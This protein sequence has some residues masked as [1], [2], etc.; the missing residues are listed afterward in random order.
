[1]SEESHKDTERLDHGV[2]TSNG[3]LA[4][5]GADAVGT[6]PSLLSP[7]EFRSVL[8]QIDTLGLTWSADIPPLIKPKDGNKRA[9]L[10]SEEYR[11]I[12]R[13][14]PAFPRE[15]GLVM[16]YVLTG[17]EMAAAISGDDKPGFESKAAAVR[18]LLITS[19]YKGEFFFKYA[20]KV[21]YLVDV[22]WEIVIKAFE[23]NVLE[24]PRIPY[25]LLSLVFRQPTYPSLPVSS[26]AASR[27][28][29]TVAV[30]EHLIDML[31]ETL[32]EVKNRLRAAQKI[33]TSLSDEE[34]K[35]K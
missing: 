16:F 10:L 21:P 9:V 29:V 17:S 6:Q 32:G 20:I 13:Q 12:Q 28:M 5:S 35:Q 27:E 2:Q 3:A 15:L 8:E 4:A 26:E 25:A 30:N 31:L 33:S 19:E 11:N 14:Y 18:D 34:E 1:M 23:R 7:E 22:D 24:M